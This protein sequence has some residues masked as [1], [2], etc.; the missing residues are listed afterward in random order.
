MRMPEARKTERTE[1]TVSKW[2]SELL[3]LPLLY[4]CLGLRKP[5]DP[6]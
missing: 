5:L 3:I 1:R 4:V 2:C 6:S